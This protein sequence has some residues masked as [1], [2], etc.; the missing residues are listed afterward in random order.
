MVGPGTYPIHWR[1]SD[2][3]PVA[4]CFKRMKDGAADNVWMKC[5]VLKEQ[6]DSQAVKQ[7]E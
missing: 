5:T 6:K 2:S 1:G 7:G 3:F 4:L